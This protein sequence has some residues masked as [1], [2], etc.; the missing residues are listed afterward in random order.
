MN[1]LIAFCPY[2][3]F[4]VVHRLFGPLVGMI[5]GVLGGAALVIYRETKDGSGFGLFEMGSLFLF[6]CLGVYVIEVQ[7][8][9][10]ALARIFHPATTVRVEE[11]F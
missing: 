6:A 4:A 9:W 10:S 8:H 11:L 1:F 7:P 2:I 3:A 5:A